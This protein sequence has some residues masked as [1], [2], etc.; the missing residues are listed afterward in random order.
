MNR[1]NERVRSSSSAARFGGRMI[2]HS[3]DVLV[4]ALID[5]GIKVVKASSEK[6]SASFKR[7]MKKPETVKKAAAKTAEASA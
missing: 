7:V 3:A 4:D 2:D 1:F 6:I 5:L